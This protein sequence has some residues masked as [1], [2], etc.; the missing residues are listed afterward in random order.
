MSAPPPDNR[1]PEHSV[2][3]PADHSFVVQFYAESALDEAGPWRGRVEHVVTG[4]AA[5]FD[6]LGA[7]QRFLLETLD[8]RVHAQDAPVV[9]AAPPSASGCRDVL[10]GEGD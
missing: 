9:A 6:H 1:R 5:R 4:R 8:D 2:G 10:A 3:L 7:L